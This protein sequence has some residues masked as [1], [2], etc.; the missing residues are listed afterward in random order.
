MIIKTVKVG[1]YWLKIHQITKKS[2]GLEIIGTS[3]SRVPYRYL[4]PRFDKSIVYRL[5]KP[6][7]KYLKAY[8]NKH[9]AEQYNLPKLPL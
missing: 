2:Y 6:L 5:V 1:S 4:A 9:L 8:I 7:P 3:R